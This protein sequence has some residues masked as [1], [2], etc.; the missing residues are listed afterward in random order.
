MDMEQFVRSTVVCYFV[1]FGLTSFPKRDF[2]FLFCHADECVRL[3]G[4]SETAK[5]VLTA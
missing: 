5:H 3:I 1:R 2:I 4:M